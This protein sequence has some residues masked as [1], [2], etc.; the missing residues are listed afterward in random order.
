M[1]AVVDGALRWSLLIAI[2][3]LA[4]VNVFM[5]SLQIAEILL[6][7][8]ALDWQTYVLAGERFWTG[9]LYEQAESWYGWRYSPLAAF[10]FVALAPLGETVWRVLLLASLLA[11]PRRLIFLALASYPL[12]FAI[13]AGSLMVL[14]A[15]AAFWALRGRWWAVGAFLVL[16]LLIPRPLMVPIVIWILWK[17][18]RWRIPFGVL[19]LVHLGLVVASGYLDDWVQALISTGGEEIGS[20]FNVAPSAIIGPAWLLLAIPLALWAFRARRPA[21]AGLLIQPYWL[22]YYLLIL[23]ADPLPASSWWRDHLPLAFTSRVGWFRLPHRADEG[24][25]APQ[26]AAPG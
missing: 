6:G 10:P 9:T 17:E 2:G 22:P 21:L 15:V 3:F 1:P 26:A 20:V 14:V 18:P 23:L 19:F 16:A 24:G 7:S 5:A 4:A 12:W 11:L 13:H 25:A 8:D